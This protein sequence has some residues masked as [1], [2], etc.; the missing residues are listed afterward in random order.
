MI[1]CGSSCRL[2]RHSRWW[3]AGIPD[4]VASNMTK[5]QPLVVVATQI[6]ERRLQDGFWCML[7]LREEHIALRKVRR[8]GKAARNG[9]NAFHE[10]ATTAVSGIP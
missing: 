1:T 9:D 5:A 10:L 4:D 7:R 6:Q 2:H 8:Q 3:H